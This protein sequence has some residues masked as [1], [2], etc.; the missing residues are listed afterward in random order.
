MSSFKSNENIC[1]KEDGWFTGRRFTA[2]TLHNTSCS[3]S[4]ENKDW[5]P[6]RAMKTFIRKKMGHTIRSFG[7]QSL[8]R[9]P[10]MT[11]QRKPEETYCNKS[12]NFF[13]LSSKCLSLFF[14]EIPSPTIQMLSVFIL[15]T[16]V[17]FLGN[18][19]TLLKWH[20]PRNLNVMP[21]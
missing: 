3:E 13:L 18:N 10:V 17:P 9:D 12:N 19:G 1:K 2:A 14:L 7:Y 15:L 20:F 11:R 6:L 5:V 8:I 4:K 16:N 21:W